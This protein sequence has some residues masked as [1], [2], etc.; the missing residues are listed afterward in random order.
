MVVL[1]HPQPRQKPPISADDIWHR[2]SEMN[3]S[4]TFFTELQGV[5]LAQREAR[6]GWLA[7]GRL[8][9]RLRHLNMHVIESQEMMGRLSAYSKLNAHPAFI[10]GLHDEGRQRAEAWLEKNFDRIGVRS[11]F[12][13]AKLFG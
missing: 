5:M 4:S 8:E 7:F 10:N 1:L 13:L 3:F 12:T 11:S 9:K 6:R 2:L